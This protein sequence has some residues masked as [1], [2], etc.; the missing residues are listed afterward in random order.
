LRSRILAA[1]SASQAYG[2]RACPTGCG[3]G[4]TEPPQQPQPQ[5]EERVPWDSDGIDFWLVQAS[6]TTRCVL[7]RSR[8]PRISNFSLTSCRAGEGKPQPPC[9]PPRLPFC[10]V[11]RFDMAARGDS[12]EDARPLAR[13]V[14][15]DELCN[16]R[17]VVPWL[18]NGRGGR[19]SLTAQELTEPELCRSRR[20]P[21]ASLRGAC[22]LGARGVELVA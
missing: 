4:G 5:S 16:R 13:L 1:L 15:R 2:P 6:L 19:S 10:D 17:N 22:R 18:G 12:E 9:C 11:R 21:R 20:R 8:E 7:S 3:A 14:S